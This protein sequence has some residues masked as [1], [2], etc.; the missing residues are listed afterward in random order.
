MK[1]QGVIRCT[2]DGLA[3]YV[4]AGVH[5]Q[6]EACLVLELIDQ[7]PVARVGFLLTV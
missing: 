2:H 4:E 7:F 3:P 5:Q 6:A 1:Q